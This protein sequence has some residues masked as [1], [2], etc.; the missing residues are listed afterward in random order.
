MIS[1]LWYRVRLRPDQIAAGHVELIRRRF[2]RA[3]ERVDGTVDMCLFIAAHATHLDDLRAD[4]VGELGSTADAVFFS[5]AS[6]AAIPHVLARYGAELCEPPHRAYAAL[7]V[8][9]A[10]HWDLLPYAA[11]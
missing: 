2:V 9:E 8:G 5:P 1:R 3:V 7:L 11:H 10:R 6:I 4:G